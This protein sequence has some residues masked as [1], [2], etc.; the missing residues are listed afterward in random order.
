MGQV[1]SK[2][3]SSAARKAT[4]RAASPLHTLQPWQRIVLQSSPAVT[5]PSIASTRR[6]VSKPHHDQHQISQ[7]QSIPR[8]T[9]SM[10]NEA[11]TG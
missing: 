11:A 7:H 4:Q 3:K 9:A 6:P 8:A 5:N 1:G 10:E 2:P